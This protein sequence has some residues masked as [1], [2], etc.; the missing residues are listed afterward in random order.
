MAEYNIYR[1]PYELERLHRN[2]REFTGEME[3]QCHKMR[4]LMEFAEDYAACSEE[5]CALLEVKDRM[6]AIENIL[7]AVETLADRAGEH[8]RILQQWEFVLPRRPE[9]NGDL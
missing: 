3:Q 9:G 1:D 2:L 4:S 8:A 6:R 5:R 7:T